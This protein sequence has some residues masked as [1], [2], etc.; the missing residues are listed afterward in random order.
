MCL[1]AI[2]ATAVTAAPAV[3]SGAQS[4]QLKNPVGP[5]R[6]LRA[7]LKA[8]CALDGGTAWA[9]GAGAAVYFTH[10]GG[11]SWEA[12][13]T[14][15]PSWTTWQAVRFGDR[16]HGLLAGQAGGRTY[17]LRSADGGRTWAQ[18]SLPP[19]A[20]AADLEMYG[21]RLAWIVGAQGLVLRSSDGGASWQQS[22]AGA[23]DLAAVDFTSATEGVAVG[24]G[25]AILRTVDGGRSWLPAA[26]PCRADLLDL[27]MRTPQSGWAVGRLGTVLS[28]TDGGRT[29]QRQWPLLLAGDLVA[30]DFASQ[31]H[32]WVVSGAGALLVTTD[33]GRSWRPE[34]QS[35][36][37]VK[38]RDVDV[39]THFAD[40]A[41][42]DV[43][44]VGSAAR[45]GASADPDAEAPERAFTA[46]D[47]GAI[48]AYTEPG[49][50]SPAQVAWVTPTGN[51]PGISTLG[52]ALD[53]YSIPQ[54]VSWDGFSANPI[55]GQGLQL[56]VNVTRTGSSVPAQWFTSTC[57]G[58]VLASA[59]SIGQTPGSLNFAFDGTFSYG[60][61]G[62]AS[63]GS[64][65]V[66]FGQ[67]HDG[68]SQNNW[69]VGSGQFHW[70]Y[71]GSD[72]LH[73][74]GYDVFLIFAEDGD[75][76]FNFQ[77]D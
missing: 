33:G 77:W 20:V 32:G 26:S 71:N 49:T 38:L 13:L 9:A 42:A 19:Y 12:Q 48:G 68:A 29:W 24:A 52:F 55:S 27:A 41:A 64:V 34:T 46:G 63:A 5:Q 37:A 23:A 62:G 76:N 70:V 75:D 16:R 69:W 25:G 54:T 56:V 6:A 15:A 58:I 3:A 35:M 74:L 72:R 57:D 17:V 59:N 21:P 4:W 50:S 30:V 47:G 66:A 18:A 8:V 60:A 22:R 40:A 1:A 31:A 28:T 10:D 61:G 53:T 65:P 44:G 67:G 36:G 11:A 73:E 51:G 45:G 7:D 2:L 39:A 43:A 14:G